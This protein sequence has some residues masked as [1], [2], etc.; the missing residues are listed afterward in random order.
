MDDCTVLKEMNSTARKALSNKALN[1]KANEGAKQERRDRAEL[2]SKNE[3]LER[4]LN[5]LESAKETTA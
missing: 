1:W 5:E 3:K 2:A 4:T